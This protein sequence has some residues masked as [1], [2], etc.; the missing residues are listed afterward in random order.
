MLPANAVIDLV[1]KTSAVLLYKAVF[2]ASTCAFD[3]E[4]TRGLIYIKSHWRGSVGPAPSL[5][6]ECV[7]S[8]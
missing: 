2:T 3:D 7:P 8:P 6:A 5:P 4:A 1:R